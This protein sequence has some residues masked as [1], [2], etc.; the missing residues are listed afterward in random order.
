MGRK[1]HTH[2]A[3]HQSFISAL[4]GIALIVFAVMGVVPVVLNWPG[5]W[6]GVFACLAVA[7][8]GI[9]L[10]TMHMSQHS[11]DGDPGYTRD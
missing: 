11:R 2:P 1:R 7:A 9:R 10:I 4:I 6:P 5:S 3:G 8:A